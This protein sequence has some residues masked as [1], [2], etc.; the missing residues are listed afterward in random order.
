MKEKSGSKGME[1]GGSSRGS[2]VGSG[3]AKGSSGATGSGGA[4]GPESSA[5]SP[6][7]LRTG[8]NGG[9]PA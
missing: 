5:E 9:R 6:Q 1:K 4:P 7:A 8:G 3:G 2:S